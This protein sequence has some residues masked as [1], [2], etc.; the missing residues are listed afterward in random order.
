MKRRIAVLLLVLALTGSC[1]TAGAETALL[2]DL[3][4][5]VSGIFRDINL[6]MIGAV[7]K[8]ILNQAADFSSFVLTAGDR[9]DNKKMLHFGPLCLL[10]L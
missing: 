7:E 6:I 2:A 9:I 8:G 5:G 1:L 3:L 4:R 10:Y